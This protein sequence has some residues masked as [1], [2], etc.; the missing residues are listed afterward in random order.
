MR[1][2]LLKLLCAMVIAVSV[3]LCLGACVRQYVNDALEHE[4][5][6]VVADEGLTRPTDLGTSPGYGISDF[7]D[8]KTG[9]HYIIVKSGEGVT[10]TP[11]LNPDGSIMVD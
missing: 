3:S 7:R 2:K 9:V 11:R 5:Y 8:P 6:T 10:I 4:G 1:N